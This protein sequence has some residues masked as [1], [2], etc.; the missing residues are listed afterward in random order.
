MFLFKTVCARAFLLNYSLFRYLSKIN[1]TCLYETE[2]RTNKR[3]INGPEGNRTPVRKP[4]PH[5]ISHHSLY[6]DIPSIRR[7]KTNSRLQ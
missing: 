4:I 7:L 6:F 5:G 3:L 1:G 2:Q